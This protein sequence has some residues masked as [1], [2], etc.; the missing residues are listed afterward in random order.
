MYSVYVIT[1]EDGKQYVGITNRL[2]K[3]M[4]EHK[5]DDRFEGYFFTYEII[6]EGHSFEEARRIET[7]YVRLYDTYSNGLNKTKDGSGNNY[8]EAFTMAGRKHTEETKRKIGNSHRGKKVNIW[9]K[10]KKMSEAFCRKQSELKKGKP[11]KITIEQKQEILDLYASKPDVPNAGKKSR[12]G[13]VSSYL[14]EFSKLYA[15]NYGI[16]PAAIRRIV[17]NAD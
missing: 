8:T 12:N 14:Q 7:L 17:K 11:L 16:T 15:D 5:G 1:R 9:N 13:R 4:L 2:R 3:R 6:S 10:G